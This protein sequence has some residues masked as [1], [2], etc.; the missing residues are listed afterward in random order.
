MDHATVRALQIQGFGAIVFGGI[1]FIILSFFGVRWA[2]RV[3]NLLGFVLVFYVT[4]G[5]TLWS[6]PFY[7]THW[8]FAGAMLLPD[9]VTCPDGCRADAITLAI[10][11]YG[12]PTL[13][14]M[15]GPLAFLAVMAVPIGLALW[16]T[17]HQ[18][19]NDRGRDNRRDR[20]YSM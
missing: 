19:G 1:P 11:N 9:G 14:L 13:V 18:C 2:N 8:N 3:A 6:L 15:T 12:S 16:E 17:R 20:G 5:Q 10:R 4:I 7:G